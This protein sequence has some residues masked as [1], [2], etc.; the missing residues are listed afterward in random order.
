MRARM[1]FFEITGEIDS[2]KPPAVLA[3]VVIVWVIPGR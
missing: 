2:L 3:C 1:I